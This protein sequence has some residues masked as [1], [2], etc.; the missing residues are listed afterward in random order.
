M[1][2]KP[3]DGSRNDQDMF[4]VAGMCFFCP[5]KFNILRPCENAQ[6]VQMQT[7]LYGASCRQAVDESIQ[8]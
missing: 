4:L 1:E 5:G 7:Q 6:L 2:G 8:W 3:S